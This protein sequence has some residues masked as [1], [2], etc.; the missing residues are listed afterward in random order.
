MLAYQSIII[1]IVILGASYIK[2][3][4]FFLARYGRRVG[5]AL[6][7]LSCTALSLFSYEQYQAWR[8]DGFAQFFLPPARSGGYFL[9][10]VGSRFFAPYGISLA[11]AL[12]FLIAALWAN[13]KYHERFFHREEMYLAGYSIFLVGYPGVLVYIPLV[14]LAYMGVHLVSAMRSTDLPRVPMYH[15]WVPLAIFVILV[16]KWIEHVPVWGRLVV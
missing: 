1:L 10:Y 6:I 15:L 13:K 7:S 8:H 12:L 4:R 11:V 16:S 3:G 2:K 5:I 14:L 9:F